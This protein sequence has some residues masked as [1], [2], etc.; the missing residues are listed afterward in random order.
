[1]ELPQLCNIQA[2]VKEIKGG[3]FSNIDYP[4]SF[5]SPSAYDTAWLA[6]IPDSEQPF[7]RPMFEN[8]LN[9]VL[10]NQRED[11]SWGELDGHGNNT[12]E[13]L[14]AT[15][16]CIIV[17][18][19]WNSG[20]PHQIQNG[21]LTELHSFLSCLDYVRAN[22]EKLVGDNNY[23][24]RPR[25]FAIVFPAML[26]LASA[27]G[28]EIV[29]P[30]PIRGAVI[31]IL[32]QRQQILD[33]EELVGKNH[34]PPL[35][36]Y[37][38]ALPPLY[39]AHQEQIAKRLSFDGSLF[40][41]PSATARAY[42][43]TGN[44]K[45]LAYL[46]SL[47]QTCADDGVP[48]LYPIDEDLMKLCIVNQLQRLGLAEHFLQEIKD[49]LAQVYRNYKNEELSA[50]PINSEPTQLYK[51]SLAFQLLRMHGYSV[52]PWTF[53]WFLNN[54]EILD[55]IEKNPEYFSSVMLN[56]YRATDLMFAEEYELQ[57]ARSFARKSL[58][59]TMT[60]GSRGPDDVTFTSFRKVIEHELDFPWLTRM[61][62]LEYRMWIEEKDMNALWMGK[63]SFHRWSRDNNLSDM[64]FGREKTTYCYFATAAAIGVSLPYDSHVRLILA[65]SAI[66]ITVADDFFDME[67]SLNELKSL[68]DAVKRWD[69]KGLSG[70][71]KTIFG[72]LDSLV[73]ELAEKHLQQQGR[74][75]TNDLKD[76]W[77]ETFAS[78]LT[79]AT[80]SKSGRTPSMEEYLETGMISIAAHTLV[81]TASCFLNPSLP[82]YKFRPAQYDTVTKLLMLVPR[83]LNDIQ[84][85]QK[86]IADGKQNS[87]ILYLRENPEADI[88]DS[89]A[90]VRELIAT[91]E[92]E[93]LEHALMDGFS[94]LPRPCKQLHL[95]CMKAFQMFFH[96]SNRY[97]SNTEMIDDVQKAF[98]IPL[99]LQTP[100][101]LIKLMLNQLPLPLHHHSRSKND[102][103]SV[104]NCFNIYGKRS[105]AAP[106]VRWPVSR[107][108]GYKNN[109]VMG[110]PPKIRF[111]FF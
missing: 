2:L 44:D 89:V 14:P 33:S 1:M 26:E 7:S 63:A 55:E 21:G 13:S 25:W 31:D 45:C 86:E 65:K 15:L 106:R 81:L 100:K 67:G 103:Q 49:V 17:L 74:D 12:I 27:V 105:L 56:V 19:R 96:S 82:N 78:W 34:Y 3:M 30:H 107:N 97:D 35:L 61:E 93:L 94:D 92:K 20:N 79:E 73:S 22:V 8:C 90:Y 16:A 48:P 6:M 102:Y 24:Q 47:V 53:C 9:W 95:F 75:I 101:P 46:Q 80:W 69:G 66:L 39:D 77:Y 68:A 62:H 42:M 111:S 104:A 108:F 91:K 43:A 84:S 10:N 58:E 4:N 36:A 98:Y 64:G 99:K 85:Y 5:V 38:E 59:K 70:H 23:E 109:I 88:E 32:N 50:N 110:V 18:K 83:L 28:L 71:S 76:I 72:A 60:T 11:G 51:D 57:E 87:V 41:S 37:L 54:P 40:H 29:F 52:S